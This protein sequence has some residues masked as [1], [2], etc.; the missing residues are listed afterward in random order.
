MNLPNAL[1][2]LD[3]CTAICGAAKEEIRGLLYAFAGTRMPVPKPMPGKPKLGAWVRFT[4]DGLDGT[5][6]VVAFAKSSI[7]V[8]F[9]KQR[10]GYGW[11]FTKSGAGAALASQYGYPYGWFVEDGHYEVIRKPRNITRRRHDV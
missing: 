2:Y 4:E 7:Y 6:R 1:A 11:A 5:G 9:P 3:T 10:D 8:A